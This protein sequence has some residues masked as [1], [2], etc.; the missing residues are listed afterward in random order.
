MGSLVKFITAIQ[1][2]TIFPKL[3]PAFYKAKMSISNSYIPYE[4]IVQD[5]LEFSIIM[6]C[7]DIKFNVVVCPDGQLQIQYPN[8]G[9]LLPTDTMSVWR[10]DH[11]KLMISLLVFNLNSS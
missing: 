11:C 5:M 8:Q 10:A 3:Y 2:N 6:A 7:D 1:P 9:V 4:Y